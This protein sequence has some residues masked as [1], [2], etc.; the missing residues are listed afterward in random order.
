VDGGG[1]SREWAV[2]L[3]REVVSG[4]SGLFQM[5]DNGAHSES[6]SHLLAHSTACHSLLTL[7]F[8]E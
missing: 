3:M 1:L 5:E 6:L 8:T 7:C 4:S 2:E